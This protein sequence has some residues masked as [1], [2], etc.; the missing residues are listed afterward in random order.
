MTTRA[1][2]RPQANATETMAKR[3]YPTVTAPSSIG[4]SQENVAQL[5]TAVPASQQSRMEV[6]LRIGFSYSGDWSAY[7]DLRQ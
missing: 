5:R 1:V 3:V 4:M 2:R 6:L 7:L